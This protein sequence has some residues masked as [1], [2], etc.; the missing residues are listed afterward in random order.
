MNEEVRRSEEADD[1]RRRAE[2]ESREAGTLI[3]ESLEALPPEEARKLLH[4][5]LVH[6]IELEMQNEE[7]RRA[8]EELEASR[9]R[10]FDLFELAPMGYLSVNDQGLVVEA[11]LTFAVMVGATRARGPLLQRPLSRFI[12]AE[13]A[14]TY[15]LHLR[16]ILKSGE[17]QACELRM[18][19]ADGD[20]FWARLE[21]TAVHDVD[22]ATVCRIAVNDI[23][24]RKQ[25]EYDKSKLQEQNAQAQKMEA[26][27][28]LAGGVAHDLNNLLT[29]IL[30]YGDL[31]LGDLKTG[32]AHRESVGQIVRAAERARDIVGRLLAFSRNQVGDFELIDL[33]ETAEGFAALLR[34]SIRADIVIKSTPGPASC[35]LG[36]RGQLEQAIMNLA[37]NAQ[38]AM[39]E[40]GVLTVGTSAVDVD[41][42]RASAIEGLTPGRYAVLSVGDTGHGM[43]V[44]TQ[45]H[46][47]EP[48]FTTKPPGSGTGLGLAT[49]YGIVKQHGGAVSVYSEPGLGTTFKIYFPTVDGQATHAVIGNA[50]G[51]GV[52]DEDLRGAEGILLVDDNLQVRELTKAILERLGYAV[53]LA[54]TGREA[55]KVLESHGGQLHL[56]LTDVV[57]PGMN[58]RELL[59]KV[60]E[61]WP[62]IRAVLMSG[63]AEHS[64]VHGAASEERV[65]FVQKPFTVEALATAVRTVLGA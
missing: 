51:A 58:G 12:V 54:E 32:D 15:Y 45:T 8:Q 40:G 38:D 28:R 47:F 34:H 7:L 22:G 20:Q 53:F 14:N 27:G 50:N 5:L 2:D 10:Y 11:N 23:T 41:A 44:E 52:L 55:L 43:D 30:G 37:V 13:D 31:L 56:L 17:P 9:A 49:V 1:L 33:S 21:M 62:H 61:T 63:Y 25:L 19:P 26:V 3:P 60:S 48:F 39:P 4:E 57:M 36:D 16:Q 65:G 64:M 42:A 18:S 24:D 59:A 35:I 29:P 6:Q 46:I